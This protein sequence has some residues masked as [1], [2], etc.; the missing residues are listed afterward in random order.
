MLKIK[1]KGSYILVFALLVPTAGILIWMNADK[2]SCVADY[3]WLNQALT[4]KDKPA[5]SKA[6]YLTL[7]IKIEEQIAIWE[8]EDRVEK[9][10]V[11]FRDLEN[12]PTLGI[13]DRE[14]F[15]PAS[16][17]K[18]PVMFA[19]FK[20]AEENP[21][22]LE[23]RLEYTTAYGGLFPQ[24]ITAK[25]SLESGNTYSVDDLIFRMI[26]YSDNGAN[27]MLLENLR[28]ISPERNLLTETFLE[29]GMT[30]TQGNIDTEALSAKTYASFFRLL[31]NVSYLSKEYSERSLQYL[32]QSDYKNGLRRGAPDNIAV[33][34]KFGERFLA[35]DSVQLHDC[36]IIYYPHNPYLLCV[37]TK[38]A[39]FDELSDIIRTTSRMVWEEVDSRKL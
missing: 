2:G 16:L 26:A 31:Y 3:K 18:V 25:N 23:K 36:G 37:M 7:R 17:L 1:I 19:Y 12:G 11:F 4:C 32:S 24:T 8:K 9:V 20:L 38:G 22:V 13:N 35:N 14:K 29:L 5:I 39:D 28:E 33:A 10:A 21:A 15:V 6:A 34:N 27:L 30:T